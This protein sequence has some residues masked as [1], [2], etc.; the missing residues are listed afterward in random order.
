MLKKKLYSSEKIL[1]TC[2]E[3]KLH[4]KNCKVLQIGVKC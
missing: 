4:N 3:D 2:R 1:Q